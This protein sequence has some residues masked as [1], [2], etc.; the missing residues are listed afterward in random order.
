MAAEPK[1]TFTEFDQLLRE[2]TRSVEQELALE[3]TGYTLLGGSSG[4]IITSSQRTEYVNTSRLYFLKDPL[5]K[6]AIRLW[7]NYSFGTGMTWQTEEGKTKDALDAFWESPANASTLSASGQCKSSDKLLVDGEIFFALFIGANGETQIRR[8]DP[9]EITEIITDPDDI[10]YPMYY[11]REWM[12]RQNVQKTDYYR[13]WMNEKGEPGKDSLGATINKTADAIVYHLAYNT[14]TQRGNP[15]LLPA[16]DWMKQ[17]RRFLA[18]RVAVMLALARFAWKVKV[19]G[20]A[21]AVAAAKAVYDGKTPEAGAIQVENM[22]ADMQPIKTDTGASAAK[23]DGRMIKL[24]I[25]AAVGIPEQY[26]GDISTGNLATART[27]ELPLMKQFES[28]QKVWADTYT[29]IDNIVLAHAGVH[30]GDW[31]VDRDFPPIAPADAVAAAQALAAVVGALPELSGARDV[32]QTALMSLGINNPGKVLDALAKEAK[33]NPN[34]MIARALK[35]IREVAN[36][37]L[38]AL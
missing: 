36:A 22:G 4:D 8:I 14:I 13:S 21:T 37:R 29:T 24:Q 10:E 3:N 35:Q 1:A 30:E 20:G 28:Y 26:F 9:L 12:N 32:L 2:A 15:L 6:Q 19:Q 38:P 25:C 27:V 17:Y 5:A 18:S 31:Y 34:V 33:S 16:M 11:K 7:T 23:D